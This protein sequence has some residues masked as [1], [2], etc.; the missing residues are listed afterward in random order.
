MDSES[1]VHKIIMITSDD[2]VPEAIEEVA[3]YFNCSCSHKPDVT[4]EQM[5]P[6]FDLI[7]TPL[8]TGSKEYIDWIKLQTMKKTPG[9]AFY[10]KIAP[11]FNKTIGTD[12]NFS[13]SFL[14]QFNVT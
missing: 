5:Y 9:L 1:D 7:V 4:F 6:K 3:A 8:A 10:N 13:G 14:K 2:R 11:T 12:K